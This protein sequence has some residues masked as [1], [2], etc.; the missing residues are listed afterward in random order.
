MTKRKVNFYNNSYY[1]IS[2]SC[3]DRRTL[4]KD[5]DDYL[6]FISLLYY[7]NQ[8][9][10]IELRYLKLKLSTIRHR[11]Y[12]KTIKNKSSRYLRI[13]GFCLLP[14]CFSLVVEQLEN[15]GI[16]DFM[17]K[18]GT[19]YSLHYNK[20]YLRSGPIFRGPFKSFY[21]EEIFLKNV[22]LL[23]HLLPLKL[24]Q[25]FKVNKKC[26]LVKQY[27]WSSLP[28]YLGNNK[29]QQILNGNKK[30]RHD[31]QSKTIRNAVLK[32]KIP[33]QLN[34]TSIYLNN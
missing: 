16:S 10:S 15:H 20:K 22:L 4:F 17:Q 27:F 8:N 9:C 6:Y 2:N 13:I 25:R 32:G 7:L 19:S 33:D 1:Y 18:L 31:F 26:L 28:Y 23:I 34:N 12:F 3:L 5:N 29:W 14:N 11:H 30:L 24:F 21:I